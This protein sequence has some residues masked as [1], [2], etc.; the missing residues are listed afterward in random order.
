MEELFNPADFDSYKED[1][2]EEDR[3]VLENPVI[4]GLERNKCAGEENLI[5]EIKV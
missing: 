2:R 3:I 5:Q 4:S 1:N